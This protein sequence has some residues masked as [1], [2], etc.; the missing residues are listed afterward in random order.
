MDDYLGEAGEDGLAGEDSGFEDA[1]LIDAA[2]EE[3]PEALEDE[4]EGQ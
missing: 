2:A 1:G 4:M 3:L